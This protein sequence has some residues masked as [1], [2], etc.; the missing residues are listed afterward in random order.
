MRDEVSYVK[1]RVVL[2][3]FVKIEP[4]ETIFFYDKVLR[5]KIPMRRD[6]RAFLALGKF[7]FDQL[8]NIS[9][10]ISKIAMRAQ[11]VPFP[12]SQSMEVPLVAV[13]S[14]PAE[15]ASMSLEQPGSGALDRSIGIFP[16]N[17][18]IA[19]RP[20]TLPAHKQ[21]LPTRMIGNRFGDSEVAD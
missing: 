15:A 8:P 7:L 21:G 17:K 20:A 14:P 18:K 4:N 6:A 1:Q 13:D 16:R 19:Q 2:A 5:G 11:Q 10:F 3:E 12:D 9:E